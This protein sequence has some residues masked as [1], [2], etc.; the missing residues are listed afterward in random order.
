MHNSYMTNKKLCI[1][2]FTRPMATKPGRMSD[3]DKMLP[4]LNDTILWSLDY[5][6]LQIKNF[7]SP[8]PQAISKGNLTRVVAHDMVQPSKQSVNPQQKV[9]SIQVFYLI[10]QCVCDHK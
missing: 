3:Y 5:M 2:I 7:I 4:T 6:K 1:T 8:I 9:L 10:R